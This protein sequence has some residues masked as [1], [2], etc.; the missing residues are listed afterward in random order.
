MI[1]RT[2]VALLR[3]EQVAERTGVAVS[4]LRH[5]RA[6]GSGPK[7]ARIGRRVVYRAD[8]VEDWINAQFDESA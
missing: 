4:T 1:T 7:S 6:A 5:W 3:I 2:G 8:D